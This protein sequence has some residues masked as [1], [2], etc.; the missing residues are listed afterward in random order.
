MIKTQFM[1]LTSPSSPFQA[2]SNGDEISAF[3]HTKENNWGVNAFSKFQ[4]FYL[5]ITFP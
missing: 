3:L 2:Y 5:E 4:R 1:P